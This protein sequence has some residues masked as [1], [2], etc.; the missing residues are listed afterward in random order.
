MKKTF[1]SLLLTVMVVISASAQFGMM[2]GAV[3]TQIVVAKVKLLEGDPSSLKGKKVKTVFTFN[4]AL[5]SKYKVG[6]G[7]KDS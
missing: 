3:G 6:F 5:V 2:G 1:G 4:D 7:K